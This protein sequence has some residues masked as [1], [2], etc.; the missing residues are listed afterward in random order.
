MEGAA[1]EVRTKWLGISAGQ[2]IINIVIGGLVGEDPLGRCWRKF[3]GRG[4]WFRAGR[5]GYWVGGGE[6]DIRSRL[7]RCATNQ[8][9]A[10]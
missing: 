6:V 3:S 2:V 7:T 9:K 8:N 10:E 4:G 1:E 5:N